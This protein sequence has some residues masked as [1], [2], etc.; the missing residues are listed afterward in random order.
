MLC[1]SRCKRILAGEYVVVQVRAE[2][3]LAYHAAC[4][5][6]GAKVVR[7]IKRPTRKV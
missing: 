6:Q 4:V 5:P 7:A 3:R 2:V 1:C